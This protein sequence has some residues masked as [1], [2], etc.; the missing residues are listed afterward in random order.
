LNPP[1]E[2]TTF[3]DTDFGWFGILIG[4]GARPGVLLGSIVLAVIGLVILALAI[5]VQRRVVDT[6]WDPARARGSAG[7][8]TAVA[9]G[10]ATPSGTGA[11]GGAAAVTASTGRYP[12]VAP[13]A[14]APVPPPPPAD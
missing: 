7:G 13:P 14:G 6:G 1:S 5:A 3:G 9:A 10:A 11:A 12:R 4:Y 2:N 8:T